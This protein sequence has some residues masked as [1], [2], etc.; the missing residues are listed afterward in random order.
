M[1]QQFGEAA[2]LMADAVDA[3]DTLGNQG[4][5]A[6][7]LDRVA[8]LAD[9]AARP[10]DAVRLLAASQTLRKHVGMVAP[11]CYAA[12]HNQVRNSAGTRLST[13]SF[14]TAWQEGT[15][16]DRHAAV[17]FVL[18]MARTVSHP[19]PRCPTV[20]TPPTH[21]GCRPTCSIRLTGSDYFSCVTCFICFPQQI[22]A[23]SIS[24]GHGHGSS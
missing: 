15:A 17:A 2:G 10:E 23:C 1:A 13:R 4:C 3:F 24:G 21:F 6:H 16:M 14:E 22:S 19:T 9:E 11:I 7:C 5:L 20:G 8:W 18:E 12:V